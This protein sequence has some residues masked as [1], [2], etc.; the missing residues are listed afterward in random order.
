MERVAWVAG[1]VVIAVTGPQP[2]IH[3]VEVVSLSEQE[4]PAIGAIF[5]ADAEPRFE[6]VQMRKT[7]GLSYVEFLGL[8][9]VAEE[10]AI[11][12]S[13]NPAVPVLL[14]RLQAAAAINLASP[15]VT[16]GLQLLIAAGLVTEERAAEIQ[17][18]V[19]L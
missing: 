7:S 8:F 4:T 5:R 3:G 6:V 18:G 17:R 9:S 2:P 19:P 1:S 10:I 13:G 15:Q 11:K 16:E 12:A 14:G